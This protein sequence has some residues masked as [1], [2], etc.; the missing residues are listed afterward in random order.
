MPKEKSKKNS[1]RNFV[2]KMTPVLRKENPDLKQTK[3]MKLIAAEWKNTSKRK[4]KGGANA[5]RKSFKNKKNNNKRNY[6]TKKSS[7]TRNNYSKKS[8]KQSGSKYSQAP[9]AHAVIPQAHAVEPQA[10]FEEPQVYAA[11][12]TGLAALAYV[13]TNT[14]LHEQGLR[15]F[16]PS[17]L[18]L[19]EQ[20]QR[21]QQRPQQ[22]QRPLSLEI[23]RERTGLAAMANVPTNTQLHAQGFNRYTPSQLIRQQQLEQQ[24]QR[25]QERQEQ[26]QNQ[27]PL[28]LGI[29]TGSTK[30][31]GFARLK[32]A[33][34]NPPIAAQGV[35]QRPLTG[36]EALVNAPRNPKVYPREMKQK[37]TG[38]AALRK[39][40]NNS[41]SPTGLAA[42]ANVPK[43]SQL[44]KQRMDQ[45]QR[46]KGTFAG[47]R[48]I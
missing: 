20:Q 19:Q 38:F 37:P 44:E 48:R 12:P 26:Q 45:R 35:N 15:R 30:P 17:E 1:Y 47:L 29:P 10:H 23:P 39:I 24:Q 33:Y 11:Q 46:Q 34:N 16:S 6:H 14:Q 43:N 2:K 42:L 3:I 22:N 27:R 36:F 8:Q 25:Q 13:P 9:Q 4:I 32:K 21:Q 31:E 28:S 18:R 5:G 41:P 40:P 7:N